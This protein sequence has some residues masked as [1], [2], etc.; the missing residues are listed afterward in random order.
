MSIPY[1]VSAVS[2][3][4]LGFAIDRFG[5]RAFIA[6]VCPVLLIAVHLALA[7]ALSLNPIVPLVGRGVAYSVFAAALWPSVPFTCPAE[8]EGA[9]CKLLP[10][11]CA[12]RLL[13]RPRLRTM[14]RPNGPI[15]R[16]APPHTTCRRTAPL[17]MAS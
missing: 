9:A 8:L 17:Q 12:L 1:I 10:A 16:P 2:S 14:M 3:P 13:R 4:F 15:G 6:A 11:W 5:G 7:Y